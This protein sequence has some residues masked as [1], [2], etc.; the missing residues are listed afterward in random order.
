MATCP[1]CKKQVATGLVICNYCGASLD[2]A[3]VPVVPSVWGETPKGLAVMGWT[4]EIAGVGSAAIGII[5]LLAASTSA[6]LGFLAIGVIFLAA[7]VALFYL[8]YSLR[9]GR[10]W[11]WKYDLIALAI[12]LAAEAAYLVVGFSLLGLVPIVIVGVLILYLLTPGVRRYFRGL[13]SA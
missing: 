4:Q 9:R 2:V 7:G 3:R 10:P 6:L 5:G 8:G 11:A 12:V 13:Q 1:R